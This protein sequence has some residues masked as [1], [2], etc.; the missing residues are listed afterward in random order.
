M[1]QNFSYLAGLLSAGL[2]FAAYF[3]YIRDMLR[4][5]TQPE[6]ASW[7]VWTGMA[8]LS[9]VA[10]AHEGA[11]LSLFFA[12]AQAVATGSIAILAIRYGVGGWTRSADRWI[13]LAAALGMY[14]WTLTDS[15]VYAL[16]ISIG[17][18]MLGG[19]V[20]LIKAYAHPDSETLTTWLLSALAAGFAMIAVGQW[21]AILLAY[22]VYM[23]TLNTSIAMAILLGR[24]ARSRTVPISTDVTQTW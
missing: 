23:F 18:S 24:R 22:P 6:R 20:T 13:V 17:V 4:G 12:M 5:E 19:S 15:A 9:L 7:L 1:E 8:S 11:T 16:A 21:S 10:Q 14:L 3:P 2:G